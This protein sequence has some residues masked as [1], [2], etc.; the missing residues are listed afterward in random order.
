MK[1]TSRTA[2]RVGAAAAAVCAAV[3]IP[4][5]ALA[6]PGQSDTATS[7]AAAPPACATSQL[8]AWVGIPADAAAGTFFYQLELSNISQHACTLYGYPGVSAFGPRAGQL[9]SAAVRNPSHPV[10]L[11]TL[12]R[13]WTAH[14]ELGVADVANYPASVCHP[15][16]AAGL[17][18]YPPNDR[19]S[20]EIPFSFRACSKRGPKFLQVSTTISGTGIPN[21]SS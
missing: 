6:A 8:V 14:I 15:V 5:V 20:T 21:F 11:V 2:R 9:G 19:R 18:L 17:R 4:T 1:L 13:G 16:T 3:L 7:S 12:K 10:H